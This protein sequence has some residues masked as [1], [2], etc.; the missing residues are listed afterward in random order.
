[1]H[2]FSIAQSI[3]QV[4][5]DEA[6]KAKAQRVLKVTLNVGELAG[7]L[8]ESLTFCFELLAK[9]TIAENATLVINKVPIRAHCSECEI[10]F[11]ISDN[12]YFC[13]RCGKTAI[14][15]T[16]GMELQIANLEIENE[17]D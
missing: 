10:T 9:S 8:P 11:Q 6:D 15:L 13:P 12:R 1:M 3:M 16:S 17:T 5:F 7:V 14:K 4:V 2:E